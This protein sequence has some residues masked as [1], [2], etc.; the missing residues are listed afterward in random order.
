MYQ[1][2]GTQELKKK[3]KT[4]TLGELYVQVKYVPDGAN[5]TSSPEPKLIEDLQAQIDK[6]NEI[7]KGQLKV[8]LIHGK[9]LLPLDGSASDPFVK[10]T[11][12]GCKEEDGPVLKKTVNPKWNNLISLPCTFKN[13]EVNYFRFSLFTDLK[14]TISAGQ[15]QYQIRSFKQKCLHF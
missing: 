4:D 1:I 6:E 3:L 12:T 7:I 13:N 14:L 11:A 2:Q 15:S 9:K 5:D 8:K 10:I